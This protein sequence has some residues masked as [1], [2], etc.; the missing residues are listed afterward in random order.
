LRLQALTAL[1]TA[2][3]L[4]PAAGWPLAGAWLLVYAGLQGMAAGMADQPLSSR[5]RILALIA[6]D[7]AVYGGLPMAAMV[8]DPRGGGLCAALFLAAAVIG[9]ALRYPRS[10]LAF[11]AST[12]PLALWI[13]AAAGVAGRTG[14]SSSTALAAAT[15][16]SLLVIAAVRIRQALGDSQEGQRRMRGEAERRKR[17]ADA[18]AGA[19][20]AFVAAAGQ[21][22]RGPVSAILAA[23]E[24]IDRGRPDMAVR[25]NTGLIIESGRN[26][27]RLLADLSD[28]TALDSG[29]LVL[30]SQTFDL[31]ALVREAMA[32]WSAEAVRRR[33]SLT[34]SGERDL[35]QWTRGD[36]ARLRQVLNAVL[37]HVISLTDRG[38]VTLGFLAAPLRAGESKA[39][40]EKDWLI[41]VSVAATTELSPTQ[42]ARLTD[43]LN[44]QTDLTQAHAMA[45]ALA[46][47]RELARLM[48]G[49]LYSDADGCV[50][51]IGL[52]A[53]QAEARQRVDRPGDLR[54]LAVDASEKSLRAAA[55]M[56]EPF[57]VRLTAV[58][59]TKAALDVLATTPF[60]LV[61]MEVEMPLMDGREA[62]RRLRAETGVNQFTPVIACMAGPTEADWEECRKAGMTAGVAKPIDLPALR[63]AML[64]VQG[65]EKPSR[66][67]AAA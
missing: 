19:K 33:I 40:D 8:A 9:A 31:R 18:A 46:V 14:G 35:P 67:S 65:V 34:C 49:D 60:D 32:A 45:P 2:V 1:I 10:G 23:A 11:A 47:S 64:R 15:A 12:A 58:D 37:A 62:C 66:A 50:L 57:G 28:L 43:P 38:G 54:M 4:G 59:S 44:P 24:A 21:A 27:R 13:L 6:L 22:L 3:A 17:E 61:L 41:R 30:D 42:R 53:S 48:G 56:L 29:R 55:L 5:G 25:A 16:G 63:A 39:F 52:A 7:S 26:V 20:Q 36:P 51:E